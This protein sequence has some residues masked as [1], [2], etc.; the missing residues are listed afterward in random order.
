[1]NA[2]NVLFV[3]SKI[4]KKHTILTI[5][6]LMYLK[7]LENMQTHTSRNLRIR[8]FRGR[9][10]LEYEFQGTTTDKTDPIVNSIDLET[11]LIRK[12]HKKLSSE[13]NY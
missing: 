9:S 12:F 4:R 11:I 6:I 2:K 13:I 3:L 8:Y 10:F 5:H 1:M 7:Y